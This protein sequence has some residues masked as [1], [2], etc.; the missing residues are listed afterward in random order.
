MKASP[1]KKRPLKYIL[2][3]VAISMSFFAFNKHKDYNSLK[4]VLV[5][6]KNELQAEL[7][8]IAK[9][10]KELNIKNKK[11]SRRVIKE[12]NTIIVLKDSVKNLEIENFGLIRKFRKR[13]SI[14]QQKNKILL[15]TMDSLNTINIDLKK[16][17]ILANEV[18]TEKDS[19]A[20]ELKEQNNTLAAVNKK[21][22]EKIAPA[23]KIK[24]STVMA[25]A[26]KEKNSGE[27]INTTKYN[28][29]DVIRVNFKLLENNL[30]TPGSKKIHIQLKD[31]Q[32]N[33][34][35]VKKEVILKNKDKIE[36]SDEL[37]ANYHNEEIEVLSLILVNRD[38]MEKG[39]YKVNVFID[40]DF[41]SS[42]AITL[43]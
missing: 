4:E 26:M 15:A 23:K 29:T 21:L 19:L 6:D 31:K 20:K 40:G 34:I 13:I 8:G 24:T 16:E 10:Y 11:L 39:E 7:S 12:I 17:N 28:R 5:E 36:C 25:V 35:A 1:P 30:T 43:R 27:L 3:I 14:L 9:E 22:K 41:S 33:V 38:Y 37:I 42:S 32:D 18:L 2:L